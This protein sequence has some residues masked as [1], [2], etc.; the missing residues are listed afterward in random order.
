[1]EE[2]NMYA[3]TRIEMTGK[4]MCGRGLVFQKTRIFC[5]LIDDSK[6]ECYVDGIPG[7]YMRG[8]Q[9]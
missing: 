9:W 8:F 7:H 3:E 5:P 2:N 1:M 4:C 6:H